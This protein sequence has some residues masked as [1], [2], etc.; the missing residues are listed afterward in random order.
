MKWKLFVSVLLCA[1]SSG[2][3]VESKQQVLRAPLIQDSEGRVL[4][5]QIDVITSTRDHWGINTRRTQSW[6][7]SHDLENHLATWRELGQP[8]DF[9]GNGAANNALPAGLISGG[10]VIAAPLYRPDESRTNVTQAGNSSANAGA[11]SEA[12]SAS[13]SNA[14]ASAEAQSNQAQSQGQ[15]QKQSQHQ[16]Q[17]QHQ[18]Q[19]GRKKKH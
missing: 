15:E 1:L 17:D 13:S 18:K 10:H 9:G 6:T 2:C 7:V 8:G 4:V 16:K 5:E 3:S 19:E 12:G 14:G 11:S